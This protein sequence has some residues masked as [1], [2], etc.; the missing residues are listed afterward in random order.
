MEHYEHLGVIGEGT[1][2]VVTKARHRETGQ[3]VAIKKFKE[4]DQDEQV[5]KTALREVRVLKQ[6]R[7]E[8]IINLVES[9]RRK[10]KLHLV[11]EFAEV[12]LLE[13]LEKNPYGLDPAFVRKY[14]YQLLRGVEYCH[15]H[16]IAH[17]DIK[18][19][20][21]LMSKFGA[22]KL[23]DFGFARLL[24]GQ[25]AHYTDYVSTRWYR[26]PEL[27][28]GD[29]EYGKPV[30]V[31][32]IGCIITEISN[33]LPLFPG[34]SDLDQLFQIIKCFGTLTPRQT[35][36]FNC[37]PLYHGIE[38]PRPL[39]LDDLDTRFGSFGDRRWLQL[40][41]CC[42][43]NDPA[44][45]STCTG[46]LASAYFAQDGFADKYEEELTSIME[47]DAAA[48][49]LRLRRPR[50]KQRDRSKSGSRSERS[51]R[52][53]CGERTPGSF[54]T[55]PGTMSTPL[56]ASIPVAPAP[57]G[58]RRSSRSDECI[59]QVTDARW[60]AEGTRGGWAGEAEFH[61]DPVSAG[62]LPTLANTGT[63]RP[64]V[65]VCGFPQSSEP[66]GLTSPLDLPPTSSRNQHPAL[67]SLSSEVPLPP[68]P[69]PKPK[70]KR[71]DKHQGERKGYAEAVGPVEPIERAPN[72][73]NRS[74]GLGGDFDWSSK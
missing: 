5:R 58:S 6:L 16:G 34:E 11:F 14:I 18:P 63:P 66:P 2:G 29:T 36:I 8:N 13:L 24:K 31:W 3:L 50:R 71:K 26:C 52:G 47:R 10:G 45:R 20:N 33:G 48:N 35:V 22:L 51:E 17:R 30:D 25:G 65:P 59:A 70:K 23:C 64:I 55:M 60:T 27:L 37:N 32:A 53:E 68:A 40:V 62:G 39:D 7:H 42:M 57:P 46:L 38:L 1:Y 28:V 9:F 49:M 72:E 4:T 61:P 74:M 73:Q 21:V 19:E 54:P 15:A 69:G 67:P 43:A 56:M 12:T 44:Q 41:K